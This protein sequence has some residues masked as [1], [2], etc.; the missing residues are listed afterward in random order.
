M[1]GGLVKPRAGGAVNLAHWLGLAAA[2]FASAAVQGASGFGFAVLAAPFYLLFVDPAAA[3]QIVILLT[4]ALSAAVLRG[5]ERDIA[6]GRLLRLILGCLAGLPFGLAGFAFSDP[7]TVRFLV[8]ATILA[9]ASLLLLSRRRGAAG[10]P[11][12]LALSP[13]RD[14]ATGV[15]SGILTALVGMSGPPLLVYLVLA[16]MPVATVR[17]TLLAFFAAA[18]AATTVFH[19]ATV[20]IP[21]R[22]WLAAGILLPFAI[23]G[24]F[25][26]R[27]LGS[28]LGEETFA[29]LAI[30]LLA[31]AGL[32][33]LVAA[34][35]P[36]A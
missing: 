10:R 14:V 20:G 9:F 16:G 31:I 13:R 7:R 25:A 8:G 18:Y 27:R 17:A 36:P 11:I 33:T 23:L 6:P 2:T 34:A 21:T 29:A 32:Y 19:S 28:R 1:A 15:A 4:T 30:G 12:A 3:V 22:I 35:F 5:I 24:G 26:G